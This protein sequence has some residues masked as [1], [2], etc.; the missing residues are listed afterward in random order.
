MIARWTFS[1]TKINLY[2]DN[3]DTYSANTRGCRLTII[4]S[5]TYKLHHINVPFVCLST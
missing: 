3:L 5:P 4:M 2:E 1:A